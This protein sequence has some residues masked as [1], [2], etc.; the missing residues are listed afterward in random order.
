MCFVRVVNNNNRWYLYWSQHRVP[1]E[2]A[3]ETCTR[4][5]THT[6]YM[7]AIEALD[8]TLMAHPIRLITLS[9]LFHKLVVL[10]VLTP[11]D[12]CTD[13]VGEY[14][15]VIISLQLRALCSHI[16]EQYKLSYFSIN[17]IY[18]RFLNSKK[19][20]SHSFRPVFF[21]ILCAK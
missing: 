20:K 1:G 2:Y 19:P 4:T 3:V 7:H 15:Y 11:E 16:L 10:N 14:I 9:S 6:Q 17:S 18:G 8:F 13:C 12:L 21:Q 5:Q